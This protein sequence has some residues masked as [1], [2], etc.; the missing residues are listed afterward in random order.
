MK[1]IKSGVTRLFLC[2]ALVTMFGAIAVAQ[3][4]EYT[5]VEIFSGFSALGESDK[6]NITFGT[7]SIGAGYASPIGFEASVVRNFTWHIGLKGDFSAHF[8]NDSS[9][10]LLTG[11]TPACATVTQDFEIRTRVY[12]F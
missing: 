10:G 5:K 4:K 7:F 2:V 8:K 11:C 9:R 12:N 6:R 3:T 1:R